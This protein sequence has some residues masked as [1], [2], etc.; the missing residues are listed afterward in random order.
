MA[1]PIAA[2]VHEPTATVAT[3]RQYFGDSPVPVADREQTGV[4]PAKDDQPRE[5]T[6]ATPTG[7]DLTRLN[8]VA[9]RQEYVTVDGMLTKRCSRSCRSS[10]FSLSELL[11][12][13]C[14]PGMRSQ[15]LRGPPKLI[16]SSPKRR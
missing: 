7:E 11:S 14:C 5:T 8:R 12:G 1:P 16:A 2:A 6:D 4:T 13:T 3:L 9:P 10:R 15:A